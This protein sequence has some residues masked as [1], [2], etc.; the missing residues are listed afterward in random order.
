MRAAGVDLQLRKARLLE[1]A[2]IAAVTVV[3]LAL[4]LAT[5]DAQLRSVD[6]NDVVACVDMRRELRLMLAAQARGDLNG[7][8]AQHLVLGVDHEPALLDFAGLGGIGFHARNYEKLR[9]LH[10]KHAIM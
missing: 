10:K 8:P 1:A 3:R 5:G 2:G 4:G 7:E 6:D 9:I